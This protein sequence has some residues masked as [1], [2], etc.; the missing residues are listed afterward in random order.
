[1]ERFELGQ[2]MLTKNLCCGLVWSRNL[3]K[4]AF[5]T[6]KTHIKQGKEIWFS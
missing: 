1:M 4:N 2:E 5:T 6:E 3:D